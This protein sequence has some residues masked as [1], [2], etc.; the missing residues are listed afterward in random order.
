MNFD[1]IYFYFITTWQ[2]SK[3]ILRFIHS[4]FTK[5]Y[6]LCKKNGGNTA[7]KSRQ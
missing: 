7:K 6:T 4:P 5:I 3:G 1:F 2:K